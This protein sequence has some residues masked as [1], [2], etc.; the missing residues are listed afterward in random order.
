MK[1]IIVLLLFIFVCGYSQSQTITKTER[2]FNRPGY[3]LIAS[4][5]ESGDTLI[6]WSG[7]NYE[8]QQLT[9]IINFYSNEPTEFIE[10]IELILDFFENN[11]PGTSMN[12]DDLRITITR[13]MGIISLAIYPERGFR[14]FT[15]RELNRILRDVQKWLKI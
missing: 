12:L 11:E 14:S 8:Y 3:S 10:F 7:Q 15:K 1:S 4:I 2:I 5:S 13:N 9:D 6:S